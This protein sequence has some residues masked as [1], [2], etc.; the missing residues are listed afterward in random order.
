MLNPRLTLNCRGRLLSLEQP[1]VMGILNVTPDSFYDGGKYTREDAL[2]HRAESML[3]EGASIIDVGGMS[4]R[5]GA[6][7]ITVEEELKRVIPAVESLLLRFP[8]SLLSVD[9]VRSQVARE[10]VAAGAAIINDISAG[11]FDK[12]M[13]EEVGQMGVPYILMHMQGTPEN[14]QQQPEYEDVVREVLDFFIREVGK[15]RQAGV[16]DIVLDPGFGFGKTVAHNYRLL[17][18]M[19]VFQILDYP[20][21][22]GLS[23]KS[24]I[25]KV[26]GVA[27][28]R[29]LNGTTALN[30]VALQQGARILRVHDV[31][32]AVETIKLW[33][34]LENL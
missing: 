21:L 3:E 13:Y 14:M 19:H 11:R 33:A 18:D 4:S 32:P 1:I 26:L 15:L 31:L 16:K 7:I 22:A 27:P 25:N 8:D 34:Q 24:M 12:R 20:I 9:T 6:E 2:L 29:A 30:M 10:A 17:R 23:R 5:P 28:A